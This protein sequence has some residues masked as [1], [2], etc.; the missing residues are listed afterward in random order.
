MTC[1]ASAIRPDCMSDEDCEDDD[2]F[3]TGDRDVL[4]EY[5]FG[6]MSVK[7]IRRPVMRK[8]TS[9]LSVLKTVTVMRVFDVKNPCVL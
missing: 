2:L 4:M 5:V 3:C 1:G 8:A 9:A 7:A 6:M